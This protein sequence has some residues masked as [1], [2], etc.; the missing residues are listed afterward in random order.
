M[1]ESNIPIDTAI[2][3]PSGEP[4]QYE[5]QLSALRDTVWIHCSDGSTVVPMKNIL[6]QER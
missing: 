6:D 1:P 3:T 4:L 5:V 2:N